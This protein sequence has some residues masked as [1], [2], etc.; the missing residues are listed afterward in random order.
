MIFMFIIPLLYSFNALFFMMEVK[1]LKIF[2]LFINV[3]S[4]LL[5]I[6]VMRE[7]WDNPLQNYFVIDIDSM[8]K[9]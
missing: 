9:S 4:N 8:N 1:V 2:I 5:L 7:H 3:I 6:F